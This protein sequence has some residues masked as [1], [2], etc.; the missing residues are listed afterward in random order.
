MAWAIVSTLTC[1]VQNFEGMLA[2]RFMLGVT[3]APVCLKS[4]LLIETVLTTPVLS[5]C[6]VYGQP[7][8]HPQRSRSTN[9]Y[10]LYRKHARQLFLRSHR[11]RH[12]RRSRRRSRYRRMEMALHH[13]R[14]CHSRRRSRRRRSTAQF[15]ARDQMAHT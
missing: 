11:S 6:V 4:P 9:G 13:S 5:R 3:E 14:C 15:T 8:L 2:A 12:L 7:V 10:L 1:L